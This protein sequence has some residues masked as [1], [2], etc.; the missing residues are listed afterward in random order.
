MTHSTWLFWCCQ[1]CWKK[2][3]QTAITEREVRRWPSIAVSQA[4]RQLHWPIRVSNT[5]PLAAE[6]RVIHLR[7][8]R[9][10]VC[11]QSPRTCR[12]SMD[13]PG[14]LWIHA[15][16]TWCRLLASLCKLLLKRNYDTPWRISWH[17][18]M[19]S[20]RKV[21]RLE[22]SYRPASIGKICYRHEM[23]TAGSWFLR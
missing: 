11:R 1:L 17:Q 16:V 8:T 22:N 4:C 3:K 23:N 15:T 19:S 20:G 6:V 14:H 18:I 2:P 7:V 13:K 5:C 12:T 10:T 9:S 21:N